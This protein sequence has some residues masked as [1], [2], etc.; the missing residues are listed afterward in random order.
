MFV[1]A[2]SRLATSSGASSSSTHATVLPD[3]LHKN[4]HSHP[5]GAA[6]AA[7]FDD[8]H[9]PTLGDPGPTALA[10]NLASHGGIK[11]RV[12]TETRPVGIEEIGSGMERPSQSE[13]LEIR[14]AVEATRSLETL[15]Q[16]L[17]SFAGEP[18]YPDPSMN[19]LDL[20]HPLILE[21]LRHLDV[22]DLAALSCCCRLLHRLAGESCGWMRFY[23][24]RWAP[25]VTGLGGGGVEGGREGG[26]QDGAVRGRGGGGGG[27]GRGGGG[28]GV[29]ERSRSRSKTREPSERGHLSESNHSERG[30]SSQ[31]ST[32]GGALP[33]AIA[34][35]HGRVGAVGAEEKEKRESRKNG[36][37][38]GGGVGNGGEGDKY[39][40][41]N[42]GSMGAGGVNWREMYLQRQR[43]SMAYLGRFQSDFLAGHTSGVRAVRMLTRPPFR[44]S[45]S[46]SPSRPPSQSSSH[47]YPRSLLEPP[48]NPPF[49][50]AITA[51]STTTAAV[52]VTGTVTAVG[53]PSP[54][55]RH[56]AR[57][58]GPWQQG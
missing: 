23:C 51:V 39:G 37:V 9:D 54:R 42:G 40:G 22:H 24:E 28:G 50:L 44:F 14:R 49:S 8:P 43:R 36:V 45:P 57:R 35:S 5:P 4:H 30:S 25:P 52:T 13:S 17:G 31:V 3:L 46:H 29:Q 18:H 11:E 10:Q 20:P 48:L 34:A 58:Y 19:F 33:A 12:E 2:A 56:L 26:V 7:W 16:S 32:P 1:S 47:S 38:V 27:G 53:S 15:G 55:H 6:D 41:S 21:V